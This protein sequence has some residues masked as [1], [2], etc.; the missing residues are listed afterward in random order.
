MSNYG[1][2][3]LKEEVLKEDVLYSYKELMDTFHNYIEQ[4]DLDGISKIKLNQ[5][6]L[7]LSKTF[8]DIYYS[9][10]DKSF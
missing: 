9:I 4:S 8:Y 1:L 6:F 7:Q 3:F 10:N 2:R 5:K